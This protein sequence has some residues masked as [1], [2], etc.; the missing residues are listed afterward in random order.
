MLRGTGVFS[1][2]FEV[3]KMSI[4]P[5][6]DAGLL[7]SSILIILGFWMLGTV[8]GWK[9]REEERERERERETA[10]KIDDRYVQQ[11]FN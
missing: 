7:H 1:D 3:R 5:I 11:I 10:G 8:L 2:R 9:G 4:T 6:Y